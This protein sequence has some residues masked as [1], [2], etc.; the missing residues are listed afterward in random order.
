MLGIQQ[1]RP[2]APHHPTTRSAAATTAAASA[3]RTTPKTIKRPTIVQKQVEDTLS[4]A[5]D[6]RTAQA[7]PAIENGSA[8]LHIPSDEGEKNEAGEGGDNAQSGGVGEEQNGPSLEGVTDETR[9]AGEAPADQEKREEG[10]ES[11]APDGAENYARHPSSPLSELSPAPDD[12]D[13]LNQEDSNTGNPAGGDESGENKEQSAAD[14][15][16]SDSTNHISLS[17]EPHQH[18]TA[19]TGHNSNNN[20]PGHGGSMGHLAAIASPFSIDPTVIDGLPPSSPLPGSSSQLPHATSTPPSSS[21]GK[22]STENAEAGPSGLSSSSPTKYEP[23]QKFS[24]LL[25][26]NAELFK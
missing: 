10:E 8:W 12:D 4:P 19:N 23:T 24:V 11:N 16:P 14:T 15:R 1:T 6:E 22:K 20:L 17:S 18:A 9:Q 21:P 3:I 5:Q 26:L 2:G 13:N 25:E 7:E